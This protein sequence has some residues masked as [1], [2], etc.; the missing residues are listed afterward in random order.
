M[1]IKTVYH[2]NQQ[3]NQCFQGGGIK[4]NV[5]FFK[6]PM[7]KLIASEPGQNVRFIKLPLDGQETGFYLK[8]NFIRPKA[9]KRFLLKGWITPLWTTQ[10]AIM[11]EILAKHDIPVATIAI[12]GEKLLF[13]KIPVGGFMLTREIVG[14][15]VVDMFE[16]GDLKQ[17]RHVL[18]AVGANMAKLAEIGFYNSPRLR[19]Y[20]CTSD[21]S[22]K[23][24]LAIIDREVRVPELQAFSEQGTYDFISRS[25]WKTVKNG[26]PVKA[27]EFLS[28]IN[29]FIEA[30]E[31]RWK[32]SK[33]ELLAGCLQA[34]YRLYAER[35]QIAALIDASDFKKI[36]LKRK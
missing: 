2:L 4:N 10:E 5:E 18:Y 15:E 36:M 22:K 8:Q 11:T 19:D 13:G 20:I 9:I 35:K 31:G 14:E 17:R 26:H 21:S 29:G 28:F 33:S 3:F 1:F 34:N 24:E 7:G 27:K 16:T 23:L 30:L 32:P 12:W 6:A 25:Y